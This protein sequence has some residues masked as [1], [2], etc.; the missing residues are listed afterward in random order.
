MDKCRG[1]GVYYDWL[2]KFLPYEPKIT[3][4]LLVV[5]S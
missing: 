2:S 3:A 1:W 4:L 5:T